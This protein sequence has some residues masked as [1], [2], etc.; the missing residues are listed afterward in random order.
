[1][2]TMVSAFQ[3]GVTLL[4]LGACM[5]GCASEGETSNP[6]TGKAPS[7]QVVNNAGDLLSNVTVG[8]VTFTENMS[9]CATGCSSSFHD[10]AEGSLA[11]TV[12]QTATS[13]AVQ[14]GSLGSFQKNTSYAVN[15]RKGS[16]KYCAE[17]WQRLDTAPFFN[18][19]TTRVLLSS[20]C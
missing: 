5:S 8:S 14:A 6:I 4:L 10:V 9:Y 11:I 13:G 12:N 18:N 17:L 3:A 15:I 20:S 2:K 16:G 19:D 7:A 1:M